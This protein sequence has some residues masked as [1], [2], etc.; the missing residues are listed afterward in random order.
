LYRF[1]GPTERQRAVDPELAYNR[2]YDTVGCTDVKIFD[3][4]GWRHYL[5]V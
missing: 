5:R 4:P 1:T 2:P 3:T